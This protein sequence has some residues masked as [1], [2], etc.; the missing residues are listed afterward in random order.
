MPTAATIDKSR[1]LI[2]D[3]PN[4]LPVSAQPLVLNNQA[5]IVRHDYE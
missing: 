2:H 5:P 4:E 3:P 1:A